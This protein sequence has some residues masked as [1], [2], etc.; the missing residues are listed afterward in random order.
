MIGITNP[1]T[2]SLNL[3]TQFQL[4]IT[5]EE[6]NHSLSVLFSKGWRNKHLIDTDDMD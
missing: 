2:N 6:S 5:D 4:L 3:N 1:C